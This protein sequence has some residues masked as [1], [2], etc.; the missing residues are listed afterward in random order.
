VSSSSPTA[1]ELNAPQSSGTLSPPDWPPESAQPDKPKEPSA[2]KTK[3][4]RGMARSLRE[5]TSVGIDALIMRTSREPAE[6]ILSHFRT[7]YGDNWHI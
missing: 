7:F 5:P 3:P 1:R 4:H 2:I 6:M